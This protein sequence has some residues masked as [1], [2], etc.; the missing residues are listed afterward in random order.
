MSK[1]T[2]LAQTIQL[3][4]AEKFKKIENELESNKHAFTSVCKNR[5]E[6]IHQ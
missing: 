2:L 3:L 1:I 4:P 5:A 6:S